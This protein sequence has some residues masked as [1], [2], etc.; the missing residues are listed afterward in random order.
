MRPIEE[1]RPG[2]SGY[3]V[4]GGDLTLETSTDPDDAWA[5]GP[6]SPCNGEFA[7]AYIVINGKSSM[8]NK[9]SRSNKR[10]R[11]WRALAP[12]FSIFPSFLVC[13]ALVCT[14]DVRPNVHFKRI[15]GDSFELCER[16]SSATGRGTGAESECKLLVK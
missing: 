1:G 5:A 13:G 7:N 4:L 6:P 8:R 3:V 11:K 9:T 12:W 2:E 10:F 15:D 14:T 16:R